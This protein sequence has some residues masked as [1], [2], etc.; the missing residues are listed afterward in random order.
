MAV[1]PTAT[2]FGRTLDPN[3]VLDFGVNLAGILEPGEQIAS[4]EL[5]LFPEAVALGLTIMSGDGRDHTLFNGDTGVKF[6]LTIDEDEREN[7]AFD[8]AG[9]MLP[10]EITAVTSSDPERTRQR[11]FLVSVAQ[12]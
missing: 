10:L 12:Q 4:Y 2:S 3:E 1:P 6:W 8:G 5:V 9:I 7:G 11:T